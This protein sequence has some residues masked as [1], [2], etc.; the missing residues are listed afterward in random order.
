MKDAPQFAGHFFLGERKQRPQ[1]WS[2]CR[3]QAEPFMLNTR[4]KL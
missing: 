2:T 3:I 1:P 4:L